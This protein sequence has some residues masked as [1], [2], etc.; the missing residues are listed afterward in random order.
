[1][2]NNVGKEPDGQPCAASDMHDNIADVSAASLGNGDPPSTLEEGPTEG[3]N[4]NLLAA[5]AVNDICLQLT[6]QQQCEDVQ[7][8]SVEN[9]HSSSAADAAAVCE[10]S[11][12]PSQSTEGFAHG[13]FVKTE[14]QETECGSVEERNSAKDDAGLPAQTISDKLSEIPDSA[15]DHGLQSNETPTEP[16]LDE[17]ASAPAVVADKAET[18]GLV[19]VAG[20]KRHRWG[21]PMNG[22]EMAVD[23]GTDLA[24]G[25]KKRRSRW[26]TNEV[27][28]CGALIPKFPKEL[29]LPGGIKVVLPPAI[30]GD[31]TY[32]DPKLQQLHERLQ[33][34]GRK[35]QTNDFDIPPEGQ[36]SPSPEPVYD[37]MG[38]RLN[39]REIR[40]RDRMLEERSG[41][42]EE[43]LKDDPNFKPPS[44]YKPRKYQRKILIP[45]QEYPGDNFIGLI[46][47]PRGNTQKR[48]QKE[49]NTKIAI[50]GKGSVKEGASRDPKYDYGEDEPL[51]VLITGD[52]QADV[53]AASAMIERLLEPMDEERNE[54]K[55]LQL[56]ELAA[57]NGTLKDEVACYLCGETTH[58]ALNCPTKQIE[59]YQ[60]PSDV[61]AKVQ[62]QYERDVARVNPEA[63]GKLD[64]EYQ[65]FM[66]SL[67]GN[68]PPE[69][70]GESTSSQSHAGSISGRHRRPGDEL[71]DD[72]KLYIGNLPPG[73]DEKGLAGLFEM[74]GHVLHAVVLNDSGSDRRYGF[75]HLPDAS[76]ARACCD[77]VNGRVVDGK[78]IVVRLRSDSG[79]NKGPRV[80]GGQELD[81]CK[82]YVAYLPKGISEDGIRTLFQQY[83]LVTDVK[84]IT[85]RQTGA[86]KGYSFVTM[87]TPEAAQGA[88]NGLSGYKIEGN[89]LIVKVAGDKGPGR[90]A[91]GPTT[92]GPTTMAPTQVRPP[93]PGMPGMPGVPPAYPAP[94]GYPPPVPGAVPPPAYYPPPGFPPGPFPR[95]FPPPPYGQPMPPWGMPGAPPPYPGAM[96]YSGYYG[97]PMGP[98]PYY[99]PPYG[100]PPGHHPPPA[101]PPVNPDS[102][103]VQSEYEKF[104]NEMQTGP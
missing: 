43:L 12:Y 47:G 13:L 74:Y 93:A 96:Q 85:D 21:P 61:K 64:D 90:S 2:D 91:G 9:P 31:P 6:G 54:H 98:V 4:E 10:P 34:L 15:M 80:G 56:R 28:T 33:E 79:H 97:P 26:E 19:P 75:V 65:S 18:S 76:T 94:G 42:V 78:S 57:L 38:I 35:L 62:E 82:L 7:E 8:S 37:R 83:G 73:I 27:S 77:A 100:V 70:M 20:R 36:R 103:A 104:M 52:T 101:P 87:A 69:L 53:D 16:Q 92:M 17:N 23:N 45:Q 95:P 1:M 84:L 55:R 67:G 63:A 86:S 59:V 46:I 88:I 44:D 102:A 39:T 41:I 30:T 11:P 22:M 48:M 14:V 99:A 50:R 40:Y 71:P 25:K 32:S 3:V 29:T 24:L 72:C 49:T 81:A 68:P 51:H 60:L 5:D 58:T 66:R 89:A